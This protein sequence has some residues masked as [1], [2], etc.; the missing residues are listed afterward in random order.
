M[1][2]M[3]LFL[4]K[5]KYEALIYTTGGFET[6]HS[7]NQFL[8]KSTH[9]YREFKLCVDQLARNLFA[10]DGPLPATKRL[11]SHLMLAGISIELLV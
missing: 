7:R 8:V 4:P 6:K 5:N 1:V 10:H 11:L 9:S 2:M 3:C